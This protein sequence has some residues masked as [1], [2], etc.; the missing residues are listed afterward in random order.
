M[1]ELVVRRDPL[2]LLRPGRLMERMFEGD[3][4]PAPFAHFWEEAVP[5]DI[6]RKNDELIV[7]A[8]MP[9][10]DPKEIDVEVRDGVVTIRAEHKEEEEAKGEHFYRREWRAGFC[11]RRVELPEAVAE[12]RVKAEFK[13]GVLTLTVPVAEKAE[14]KRIE[15]QSA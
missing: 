13:N 3:W 4:L 15:I 6:S 8:P 1:A 7:R 12:D 10:Y 14:A 2:E 9:G 5:V 11:T